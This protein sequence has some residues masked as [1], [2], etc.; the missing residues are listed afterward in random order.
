MSNT[1]NLPLEIF[2]ARSE[3]VAQ[4]SLIIRK[5]LFTSLVRFFAF[6]HALSDFTNIKSLQALSIPLR[7]T[8]FKRSGVWTAT[9][10]SSWRDFTSLSDGFQVF[11]R[12]RVRHFSF[13]LQ[14]DWVHQDLAYAGLTGHSGQ[15]FSMIFISWS[16]SIP[17]IDCNRSNESPLNPEEIASWKVSTHSSFLSGETACVQNFIA[18]VCSL[19]SIKH[20]RIASENREGKGW[21]RLFRRPVQ[22]SYALDYLSGLL[23]AARPVCF[24]TSNAFL[25]GGRGSTCL[26]LG[27]SVAPPGHPGACVLCHCSV[28]PC[29][30]SPPQTN[31]YG[32]LK[33]MRLLHITPSIVQLMYDI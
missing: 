19:S 6:K 22:S 1:S 10:T 32:V 28:I 18:M 14:H 27:E 5:E 4:A 11:E 8:A 20:D 31:S 30:F 21:E 3:S 12:G 33:S 9:T 7:Y 16:S 2:Y 25:T 24:H 17:V 13:Y 23:L 26:G 29:G 15:D